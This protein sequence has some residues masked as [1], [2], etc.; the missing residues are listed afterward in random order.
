MSSAHSTATPRM[1]TAV[2]ILLCGAALATVAH[3]VFTVFGVGKPGLN[4]I[5]NEWLYD[6]VIVAGA[7]A[8]LLR[9]ILVRGDR[10]AWLMIAAGAWLWAIGD[11]YWNFKLAKLD[12]IPYPS[13]ADLFYVSGYPA[14]YAG[15]AMLTHVRLNRFEKSVWLDGLIGAL[16]VAAIGAAFLY[17]AFQGSTDGNATTVAV[18]LAYPLGDLLLAAFVVAAVALSGWR[19]DRELGPARWRPGG[20]GVCRWRLPSA[21]G[22]GRL[23]GGVVARHPVARRGNG[24]RGRRVDAG[25]ASPAGCLGHTAHARASGAVCA[26]RSLRCWSMTTSSRSRTSRSGSREH[27]S[28]WS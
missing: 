20:G 25:R 1:T 4:D 24:D 18:N 5:F 6:G 7:L 13:L 14:F 15:L 3:G 26:R 17:P 22:D 8:C 19:P 10:A 2:R 21:G 23:H 28:C 9:G 16:A 11:V 27:R 12:E